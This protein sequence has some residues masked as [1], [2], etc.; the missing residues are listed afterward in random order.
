MGISN[1][2]LENLDYSG[3]KV[4]DLLQGNCEYEPAIKI[5]KKG[6]GKPGAHR[7][8]DGIRCCLPLPLFINPL[9]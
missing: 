8:A 2:F 6:T 4:V 9:N 7:Y 3:C 1:G 5:V